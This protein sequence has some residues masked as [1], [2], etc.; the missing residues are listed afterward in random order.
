MLD[1]NNERPNVEERY[2]SACGASSLKVEA[3]RGGPVDLLVASAWGDVGVGGALMRLHTSW[4]KVKPRP[5]T[6]E[7]IERYA[8]QLP[9][10]RGKTDTARARRELIEAYILAVKQTAEAL[11]GRKQIV[12]HLTEWA[13]VKGIDT[14]LVGPCITF[15]LAPQ[16]PACYARKQQ[17]M[18]DAPILGGK[19]QHCG[20]TG[21]RAAPLGGG[22]ILDRIEH[23]ISR[24]RSNT[25]ARLH[26]RD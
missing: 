16:C 21:K 6:G 20:G 12:Q 9:Q 18:T 7:D 5:I 3:E 1:G 4:L 14:E 8:A 17:R 11:H 26:G 19:C 25:R 22:R 10:K 15:W 2:E 24:W 23:D 13:T